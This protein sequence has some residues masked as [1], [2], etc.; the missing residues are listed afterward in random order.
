MYVYVKERRTREKE[1]QRE[2]ERMRECVCR[3]KGT[4]LGIA[5]FS[6]V[7]TTLIHAQNDILLIVCCFKFHALHVFSNV[8]ISL[9]GQSEGN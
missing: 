3:E 7:Y 5:L 1:G 6:S 8:A 9:I 4:S 2:R